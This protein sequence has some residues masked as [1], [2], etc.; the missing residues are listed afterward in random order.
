MNRSA[1]IVIVDFLLI[2]LLAFSRLDDPTLPEEKPGAAAPT[3]MNTGARQD[4]MDTLKL[5]L[6]KERESRDALNEQLRQA[7]AR[8]QS[9][10]Q[11]LTEREKLIQEAEQL[12]QQ[13]SDE[14]G[15]LARERANLE[16]QFTTTRTSVAELQKQLTN[17]LT[18]AS[19][20][21][22]H[23]EAL[24]RELKARAQEEGILKRKLN[25]LEQTRMANEAEKR[26]LSTQLQLADNERRLIREQLSSAQGAVEVE[27][28]E[29][30]KLQ[31]H[32]TKL[33]E[34]VTALAEKSGELTQEIRENRPLA[35]NT[36]FHEFVTNRVRAD[37]RAVRSGVFGREVNREK[38]AKSVLLR[39]GNQVFAIYHVN[40]TPLSLSFPGI[41][42]DW[43]IGNLRH[44]AAVARIER[45]SFLAVDPRVIVV[46]ISDAKA[47][48]LGTKI[49]TLP[50]DP[51]KFQDAIL[52]GAN[53]GYYGECKFQL[54]LENGQYVR[55]QRERFSWL[56]GKFAPSSGD[57]IFTK[58]GELLGI[59]VNK[60]YGLLLTEFA[61]AYHIQMGIGIGDQQ[62]GQLLSQLYAQVM[63]MP[64]K[65]Q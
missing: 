32:A 7:Q 1:L 21:R 26:Q 8:L 35:P 9:H 14:A 60:D 43:L 15:R 63:R 40:D 25:E 45:L 47:K 65:L 59:M 11:T 64:V 37:F 39:Q 29:K 23:L 5:S 46:P 6:N 38:E 55:M 44:G 28:Q 27:R 42:W 31:E 58:G 57:L 13:K 41:D 34:G 53:E 3:M 30:A 19:E 2:S 18:E 52:V 56:V 20:S 62:T 33:A 61:P 4:V 10:E 16:Q 24:E 12:L 51:F 49:Y 17:T 48:E 54:D 36:V 22:Q 50:K